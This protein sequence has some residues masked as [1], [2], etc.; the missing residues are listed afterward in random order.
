MSLIS[1]FNSGL[2]VIHRDSLQLDWIEEFL[3]LPD[4]LGHFWRIEQTLFALCSSRFGVELLPPDYDVFVN[5]SMG[6]RPVRHYIG[7]IRHLM[8]REGVRQLTK[9]GILSAT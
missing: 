5:G 9:Q 8:Y 6:H 4:I 1:R 7:Q 2:G 3:E